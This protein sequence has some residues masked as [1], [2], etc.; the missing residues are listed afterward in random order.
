MRRIMIV[1]LSVVA[2][3]VLFLELCTFKVRP[4][5]VAIVDRFG[6]VVQAGHLG[7]GWYV[8]WPTDKVA[9][10]DKRLHLYPSLLQQMAAKGGDS[11]SVRAFAAWKISGDGTRFYQR[12]KGS[13]ES[14]QQTLALKLAGAT[15]A[16]FGKHT[17]DQLFNVDGSKIKTEEMEAEVKNLVNNGDPAVEG[18]QGMQDL[19]IEVEHVGFSRLAFPPSVASAVY[20]RMVAERRKQADAYESKGKAEADA[21][22]AEGDQQASDIKAAAE[23]KAQQ[24]RGEG[25]KEAL[26]ILQS[27]QTA[28]AQ[29]FYQFWREMELFKAG[30]KN[31][32]LVWRSGEPL[33]DLLQ[34]H[35]T[36][37][38][39]AASTQPA[40]R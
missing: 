19:G 10:L 38:L 25:D 14:A 40:G 16:V 23:R 5:E 28:D 3:V 13:D 30:F 26:K 1:V 7:Y 31:P 2:A 33:T 8:K 20:G 6:K 11:I 32:Y 34:T 37:G 39:G 24:I 17:L 15:G 35:H 29:A 4:Y 9:A 18:A 22:R 21:I 27:V 12:F 36:E